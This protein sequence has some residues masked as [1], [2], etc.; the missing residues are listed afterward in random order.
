MHALRLITTL[1]LQVTKWLSNDVT[2]ALV[3]Q[4]A[5]NLY[6]LMTVKSGVS[7]SIGFGKKAQNE[8]CFSLHFEKPSRVLRV[9]D[10][11]NGTK[12][13][14]VT[15]LMD[16]RVEVGLDNGT[17]VTVT[18]SKALSS[19]SDTQPSLLQKIRP[20]TKPAT[21]YHV[22]L[23]FEIPMPPCPSES[24]TPEFVEASSMS[25]RQTR[26]AVVDCLRKLLGEVK[27]TQ[28]VVGTKG[29]PVRRLTPQKELR[30]ITYP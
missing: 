10:R 25:R 3:R 1:V 20:F 15:A 30:T 21:N 14:L 11:I 8:Y 2:T 12:A 17:S 18:K 28:Y 24:I 13:G 23:C 6:D 29:L 19:L 27:G 22:A 16:T 9:G 5:M 26:D 7:T 4:E